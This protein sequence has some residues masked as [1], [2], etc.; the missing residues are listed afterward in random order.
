MLSKIRSCAL[1]L[2]ARREHSKFELYRKLNQK[3]FPAGDITKL[4]K[5]LADEKLQSDERF[6]ESYIRTRSNRGFGPSRI[7]TEL[8]DRGI[9]YKISAPFVDEHAKSWLELARIARTKKFGKKLPGELKK[10]MQQMR[11]LYYKGFSNT[12][13]KEVFDYEN[14]L[15]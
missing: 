12:Q 9:D 14:I 5:E 2:L 11:Y 10:K 15:D 8:A 6:I 13:I 7:K 4:L 3:G 1:N